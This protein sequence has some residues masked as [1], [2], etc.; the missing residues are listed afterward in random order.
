M[1]CRSVACIWSGTPPVHRVT[2]T[3]ALNHPPTLYTGGSDGS[4]LWWNLSNSDSHSEIRPIAMLCGHA[5]PIADLA[6]CC[7]IV[8]SGE[9]SMDYSSNVAFNSSFDNGG[10]LLS[11]CT[12]SM[13]CVWSRSSGHCRRRRKLPPWVGSP[14]IIRTLPWNPRYACVGCCFI[15]AAHLTDHQL[16]ESAEGGEISMDKESQNRKPPKCTVV[17]VD[18]YTLTIVQTVFHGNLSIGP[19]KFMDVVSSVDD[20]E[21][22]CSLLADSFGKLQLVPLSKDFHQGS[23]GETRLQKSSKQEIEAW[24]DGLVEAGQVVSIA[25]CRTTVATVL[26][27]RSIFR[28][29]DGAITIGVILFMNN[30]LCVEDDHGQSHVVGAMFLESKNYGNAQI[31]GVT[32]ESEIFLVWNNRGSAVLYAISYLDN[33][34]NYEPLCEIPAT[35]FPL[36]ARLSFSFVH[37]SQILLRVESVCFTIEDSFQWKPRVTIW[38]LQQRCDRGKLFDECKMLGQGISFLGWTPTAGLD[39]K[40]ESLG[41]FNTKLTSIQ[42]SVSVSETVDSIH[43]DD[44]CYSVPKGQTVSSSMVISENL[45]APSA[46]VYGFSSGQIQVVWFNLFRGLDS[47]AGSPR[48]EVD[49]H[50][51]KQNFAGHTGAILCLAAHRMMGAAKGWSFS[52]V[53]VSGSMDCTIRIWDL[54]SGNLVTVMHQHVGPVR[55]IILPPARTERPWSDCFLSVGEDSC[56]A[57]TSLETLRVERMFPGHPDYPAKLVWDGAR[58][59]IACLCRHHSRVSDAIDVLYIWDVKTGSRE[60]VLRGTASHSMF[61]H[62]CKEISVTSISGSSLSGN[63]SVSSLLLPIHEDGNLSQHRLNSSE[64]GVSLS[65][66]T[67]SSTLLANNSKLNSGKAPFDSRTRKQPIKCFCPYPG[68][69]TLSFDLAALIDPCQKRKRISKNGDGR[70]NSYIKEHLSEAFSPRHLNSDDGFNTDQSSTDAIE[71]HDWIKSLEEYL[72]RFSL[73]F[74]HLWDVDCGL[75]DLLIADIKLKRP[76]GFIVSSGLQGDKGSLTLTFPGF[77]SSL[78]LWKSSSEFCAMR[79]L[80]MVSLAQHMISLSHP[81]SSASSALAAFYTRNFA[82]KYPDIKPPLLQLLVSFW[83]DES[84]HVRMAARSLFHC[85]ASRAIPAPLCSQQATKHAKLLRS[86]TGIEESENEISRKEET[87]VGLSSECLLETEGT[88]QVEKAKLLGWLESYE[89]QDWISCVGGTSQDAMTSHIIVAAALVIWYPSLVKPSLATLVVQPL[90][91][92]VMAMNEKYSS[93]AAELLAEGMESTWKACIGTEI[94]RLI[95]DIFFQIECV[96]GPSANSAGENP[97]VPVSI[98]ETLVGTLLPSLAVADI[99]GFLTVI[100]SQIWSTASDSPVHLV[101][102]A[103][104]IRVVRSSPRSLVQYLDKVINFILQTMD[105]GNSVMRKTCHPR[106]MTT[107]REVIRVF[108]MV[109]MNESSTKLAFGDAIGEINGASIRVY[110]MQSA[111]KIKVLDASGPPGLPSLL[112]RAPEMSVTTVISALS[113]SPDGEGLVAFSEHGLMIRWWSLGSVW[114]EK[115]SR[116]LNPVQCTKV[117]F[118][119]PGEGFSPKTSRSSIMG[120]VLGHDTEAHSQEAAACY[121]DKLKLLIHNLDLSYRLQW[122]GERKVLLTRHGLEIGSFPL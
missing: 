53:L 120:S 24:E 32:H 109:A 70:E 67:G 118:V 105:P 40:S 66:M 19:L 75:D 73:S 92:L 14:S 42:S 7:P 83:Q 38:S 121:S 98:R 116:N 6:I 69:A 34:F 11:A 88:S 50:I 31:T 82:D 59:Y 30:V 93:T 27:D 45:Y 63:T 89:I 115:L 28:L 2:A 9:Q 106:S 80:T 74:L 16:M 96:S 122:V 44:S 58:G 57:L 64:S 101:S 65:K 119:P 81:S 78:E 111:T 36:G 10:A 61:D 90:V 33:T 71:E 62:F 77:T 37:L 29:L 56:V 25:T 107:L 17:I 51:S 104:L 43:V 21:I 3:A 110:D 103:T 114:W 79:S 20:G 39:R 97:A 87:I 47:P 8:V 76:N 49:S 113:F 41:G 4:I 72:V 18:T 95:S 86:L 85:A 13:L 46:I 54:D 22:H 60:R 26:K 102:L 84:E 1:K 5:A 99:L 12:D 48:L 55:Q 100:E 91:K 15:D 94:P 112:L 35:S 117:I 52:Q 23:E 68:I 108:P